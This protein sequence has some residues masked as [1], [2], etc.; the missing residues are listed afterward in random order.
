MAAGERVALVSLLR[1]GGSLLLVVVLL[2][3]YR[4]VWPRAVFFFLLT[5]VSL[6]HLL[7]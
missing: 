6:G 1:G 4:R 2:V 7:A 5:G 3:A